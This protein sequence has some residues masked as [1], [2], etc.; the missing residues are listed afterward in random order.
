MQRGPRHPSVIALRL[1]AVALGLS[2]NT[3]DVTRPRLTLTQ[4]TWACP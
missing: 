4:L 2:C 3:T 1:L